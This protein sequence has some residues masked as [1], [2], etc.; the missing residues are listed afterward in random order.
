MPPW[1]CASRCGGPGAG[2]KSVATPRSNAYGP[3]PLSNPACI[4][5]LNLYFLPGDIPLVAK[6]IVCTSGIFALQTCQSP[7]SPSSLKTIS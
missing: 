2:A 4:L 7:S 6:N 1:P 5:H 3:H